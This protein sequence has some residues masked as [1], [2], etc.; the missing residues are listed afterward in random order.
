[1]TLDILIVD[2][3]EDLEILI[4][5]KFR[6]DIAAHKM[7]LHFAKN[8]NDALVFLKTHPIHIVV[9]DLSMPGMDGYTLLSHL[10]EHTPKIIT[11]VMSAYDDPAYQAKAIACG[12]FKFLVK[13]IDLNVLKESLWE[14]SAQI[15]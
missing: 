7:G 4:K 12:A 13:P 2:D 8:G 5:K 14:A 1:M 11:L 6:A 15:S 9:T 3:D 10:Q